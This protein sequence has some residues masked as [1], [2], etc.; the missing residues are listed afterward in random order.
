MGMSSITISFLGFLTLFLGVGIYSAV[1]KTET[2]EDYLVASRDVHPWVAALSAVATNNSGFMFIGLIGET[3]TA[4]LSSMWIMIGWVVGDY[5]AWF[6]KIPDKVRAESEK[7]GTLT[8]PSFLSSGSGKGRAITIVGGIITLAFLGIYSAAQLS[9]GSKALNVLFGWNYNVGAI[10]GAGVVVAYCS[11]GGIRASIWTDAAQSIVMLFAM[12]VLL[13]TAVNHL[14]GFEAMWS[15][16]S[17]IDPQL[18]S[19]TPTETALGFDLF[20]LGWLFAGLGVVGQPHIMVRTMAIDSVESVAT[21]R[22]VYVVWNLVFAAAAVGVGLASRAVLP[23]LIGDMSAFDPELSMPLLAKELLPGV[24]VG[25]CL[26][27]L[28]A[29][30]MSTADSQILSCS[31]AITQDIFPKWGDR[32]SAVK[33]ATV[34]VTA[35]SLG[36]ALYA[37]ALEQSGEK[38]GVFALVAL[39]WASLASGLGPLLI[40][41]AF[42]HKVP[43]WLGVTM[44]VTGLGTVLFW[45]YGLQLTGAV[46]D[47]Y[48]GMLMGFII[49]GL[50]ILLGK[51]SELKT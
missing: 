21:A 9:A 40:I 48:P 23:D 24:L 20:V 51:E 38:S 15:K 25:L 37:I 31:A 19:I 2:T 6:L 13:L 35:L 18:T 39:A 32:Y 7:R 22:R 29:A 12:S 30:T 36:I 28:F 26:A 33:L 45:R 27:G 49:Y 43:E 41:R 50:W 46:Y 16:L 10:L 42:G 14:G 17:A 47:V 8:V 3:F 44:M 11:A 5:M 34:A 4:G 1:R